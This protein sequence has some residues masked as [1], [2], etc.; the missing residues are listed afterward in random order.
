[1]NFSK[2]KLVTEM[3]ASGTGTSLT[4][5]ANNKA[6]QGSQAGK[7][8]SNTTNNMASQQTQMATKAGKAPQLSPVVQKTQAAP[9]PTPVKTGP[10]A[11]VEYFD[12]LQARKEY[13]R[14]LQEKSSDW[15]KDLREA[16]G[17][18]DEVFHPYV[19][20]MPFKDFKQDE[21]K[22]LLA[23]QAM[24]PGAAENPAQKGAKAGMMAQANEEVLVEDD[25]TE[26]R[27]D[28]AGMTA[29]QKSIG[30]SIK[31]GMNPMTDHM[32]AA[33]R[34][35]LHLSSR[36]KKKPVA[37]SK[38][39]LPGQQMKMRKK[40]DGVKEMGEQYTN[41][42]YT[43]KNRNPDPKEEAKKRQLKQV[44]KNKGTP[45]TPSFFDK[46]DQHNS[47]AGKVF[48]HREF[49]R[50]NTFAVPGSPAAKQVPPT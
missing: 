5:S 1:M 46:M 43:D 15:R 33:T 13:N 4:T 36:G 29:D 9:A 48:S 20:V 8:M 28:E 49:K 6:S 35:R 32:A 10:Q 11:T 41:Q 45:D 25:V 22:K 21:V 44:F 7:Q 23:K 16:L 50:P 12:A 24:Q 47:G 39:V 2:L 34:Q 31:A 40:N 14:R 3:L 38:A 26:E 37:K 27:K 19:E 17:K 30:R 18:D 42:V